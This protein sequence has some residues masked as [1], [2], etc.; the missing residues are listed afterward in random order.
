MERQSFAYEPNPYY[1]TEAQ[2]IIDTETVD[3][4]KILRSIRHGFIKKVYGILLTQLALTAAVGCVFTM[5]VGV[6]QW[7]ISSGLPLILGTAVVAV[8][9]LIALLC[10]PSINQR[11][12][13]N[14]ILLG[15]FTL[16]E[17]VG[18][19][20]ACAAVAT[21]VGPDVVAQALALCAVMVLGLT[22]FA[23]QTKY[24]FVSWAGAMF[25]VFLGAA[26]FGLLRLFFP[27]SAL[28][29][30]IYA[31]VMAAIFAIYIVI[32]TQLIVGRGKIQL[33]TDQYIIAC[34]MLYIDII[35]LFLQLL[36]LLSELR[37]N[38]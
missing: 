3:D 30:T 1:D 19:G 18:I 8:A 6:R 38:N 37:S 20:G 22:V 32:D 31:G 21:R 12:P 4:P 25:F 7:V 13:L 36:K 16:C 15:I 28:V 35:N 17:S 24:D 9:L 33:T 10:V 27:R 29:E 26:A 23:F 11:Y 34:L 14:Y 5:H 2:P